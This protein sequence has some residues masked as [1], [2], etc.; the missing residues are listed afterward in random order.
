MEEYRAVGRHAAQEMIEYTK[1][2]AVEWTLYKSDASIQIYTAEA[3]D[4]TPFF[5]THTQVEG[6]IDDMRELFPIADVRALI[7]AFFPDIVDN[8]RLFTH[9][10][11]RG[12]P[13][14][15]HDE[16]DPA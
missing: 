7:A 11:R 10:R 5:C 1:G 9:Q 14:L 4:G 3:S 12:Q 2:G 6:T 15:C 8:V 16:L 13:L